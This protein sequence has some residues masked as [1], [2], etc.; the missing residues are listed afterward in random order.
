[1]SFGADGEL[2]FRSLD[3]NTNVL[4]RINKD[5]TGQERVTT[6][7]VLR[8]YRRVARRPVGGLLLTWVW[9]RSRKRDARGPRARWRA[10][11][12]LS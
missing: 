6:A 10:E 11:E 12:D 9:H 7:P 1:M 3:K 8:E 2:L 4:V 5:G